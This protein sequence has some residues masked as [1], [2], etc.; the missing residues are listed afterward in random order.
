LWAIFLQTRLGTLTVG[1]EYFGLYLFINLSVIA[2]TILLRSLVN[3]DV[4][5]IL[6]FGQFFCSSKAEERRGL[7]ALIL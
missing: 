4:F 1:L 2:H 3:F 7:E 5:K 6:F